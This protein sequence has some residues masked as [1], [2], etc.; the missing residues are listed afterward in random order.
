VV[1]P[2]GR[3]VF[4]DLTLSQS[5]PEKERLRFMS[6]IRA[7][8]LW[9]IEEYDGLLAGMNFQI[10]ERKEWNQHA[11]WTFTAV[12]RNLAAVRAEFTQR[13][14]EGAVR[15]TEHRIGLQLDMARAGNLGWC[16]YALK[17]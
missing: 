4:T 8:H 1:K 5:L 13:I 15:A 6:E 9:S 12:A 7:V 10:L 3:I 16:F 2:G 14:G 11:A 17:V